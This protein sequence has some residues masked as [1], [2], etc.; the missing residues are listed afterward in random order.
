V[1]HVKHVAIRN[2]ALRLLPKLREQEIHQDRPRCDLRAEISSTKGSSTLLPV[3]M[4]AAD[5]G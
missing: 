1:R 5:K 4:S 3:A 2:L